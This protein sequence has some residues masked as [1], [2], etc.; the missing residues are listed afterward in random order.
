MAESAD[1]IAQLFIGLK[2]IQCEIFD[3]AYSLISGKPI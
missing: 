2:K 1:R 3:S